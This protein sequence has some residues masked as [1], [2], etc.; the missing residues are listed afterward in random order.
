MAETAAGVFPQLAEPG[1][2]VEMLVP[3]PV[4]FKGRPALFLDRDGTLNIDTGYP[5]RPEE[6]VLIEALVPVVRAANAAGLPAVVVTNQSG[7]ARGLLDWAD[8]AATN[9]R[10]I[11]LLAAQG[12]RIDLVLACAYH[13]DGQPPYRAAG[14]AMR[15]PNPGMLLRAGKLMSLDLPHSLMV[16]DR[17]RDLEAGRRAGLHEA[18][19]YGDEALPAARTGFRARALRHQDD[20]TALT[21]A[22]SRLGGA[23]A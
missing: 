20:F 5:R 2:W 1:L 15:K 9:G 13:E 17:E 23:S 4:A 12:A 22:I 21:T 18:W 14:H 7:I 19:L 10:L 16:G 11:E 3:D 8:F 6:I